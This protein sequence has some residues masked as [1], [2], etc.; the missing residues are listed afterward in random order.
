MFRTALTEFVIG[1]GKSLA[2]FVSTVLSG[3]RRAAAA[4][5][6]LFTG[7]G[8]TPAYAGTAL[9]LA[10]IGIAVI[11]ATTSPQPPRLRSAPATTP[12]T[13]TDSP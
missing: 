4:F 1:R 3:L 12:P 7:R 9:A 11:A 13:R 2:V 10:G 5:A 8:K 6:G